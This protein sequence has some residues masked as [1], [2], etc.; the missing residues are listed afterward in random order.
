MRMKEFVSQANPLKAALRNILIKT[1]LRMPKVGDYIRELRW[2]PPPTYPNGAYFGLPRSRWRGA[3]G[4]PIPQPQVRTYAG[5]RA[6][7]D[8]ILGND[9]ALV[10]YGVDPRTTL[11]PKALAG[12]ETLKTRFIALYPYG[13]RPQGDVAHS[14]PEGLVEVEDLSGEAVAWFRKVG[15]KRGHVAFIRPD[16][17][18]YAMRP[19][20]KIAEAVMH[21]LHGLKRSLQSALDRQ[22]SRPRQLVLNQ[23]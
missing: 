13:G 10:G 4:R 2:K 19:A 23:N 9:F 6:L 21:G 8:E 22:G 1:L 17:V 20:D 5:R 18:V 12:L 11:D 15:A 3:E 7:L 16:K 14:A